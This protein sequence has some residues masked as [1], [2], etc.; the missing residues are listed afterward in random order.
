MVFG[1]RSVHLKNQSSERPCAA[2]PRVSKPGFGT[3][4][5]PHMN[6][7]ITPFSESRPQHA[8]LFGNS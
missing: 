3:R 2:L 8:M 1:F 5:V 7:I 4:F 6:S